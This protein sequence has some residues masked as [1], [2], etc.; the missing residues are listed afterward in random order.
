MGLTIK[1]CLKQEHIGWIIANKPWWGVEDFVA[2]TSI[3]PYKVFNDH[4]VIVPFGVS[5]S[6]PNDQVLATKASCKCTR[7]CYSARF[8]SNWSNLVRYRHT[9]R[10]NIWSL[11]CEGSL[12]KSSHFFGGLQ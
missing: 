6:E 3:H 8:G 4:V 1:E 10:D 7:Y 12:G 5:K 11:H 2:V 9:I